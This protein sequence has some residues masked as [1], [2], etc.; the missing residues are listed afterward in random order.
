MKTFCCRIPVLHLLFF[1]SGWIL[2]SVRCRVRRGSTVAANPV[3]LNKQR[4]GASA[5]AKQ[6]IKSD[7]AET[8]LD[9]KIKQNFYC[10]GLATRVPCWMHA[11]SLAIPV[12]L[13]DGAGGQVGGKRARLDPCWDE[14]LRHVTQTRLDAL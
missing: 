11:A 10:I 5:S 3:A 8:W 12:R 13:G 6:G 4:P 2:K 14:S 1:L 7:S 9:D